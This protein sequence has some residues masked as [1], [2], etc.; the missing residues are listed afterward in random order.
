MRYV[1]VDPS[2]QKRGI[3]KKMNEE[4]ELEAARRGYNRIYLHAREVALE[5][6]D[7]LNYQR[8]G[9]QFIEVGIKHH[10][11]HKMLTKEVEPK[12]EDSTEGVVRSPD[13]EKFLIEE[14]Q[15]ATEQA[16][17]L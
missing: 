6:Y 4:F 2:R 14:Y 5:F 17:T 12:I 11:M 3:G 1:A 9:E 16:Q 15:G 10:H 13:L 7:K 8:F